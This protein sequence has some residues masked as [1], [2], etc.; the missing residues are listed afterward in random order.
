MKMLPRVI[1]VLAVLSL[2]NAAPVES[3]TPQLKP[4][5]NL[6]LTWLKSMTISPTS[7]GVGG[8]ATGTVVLLRPA[9]EDMTIGVRIQGGTQI[10]GGFWGLGG[11]L[12]D[13]DVIVPAGSDR[14]TF[15]IKTSRSGG[16]QTITI[17]AGYARES[18]SATF[19]TSLLTGK[20]PP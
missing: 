3:Q 11:I 13:G 12:V 17:I 8:D 14:G 10:E 5:P 1:A 18:R 15:W 2:G 16:A 20:R 19:S 4:A 7:V 6:T 9:I